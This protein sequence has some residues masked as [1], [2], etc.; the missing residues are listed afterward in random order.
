M[1]K[2]RDQPEVD[3]EKEELLRM[4]DDFLGGFEKKLDS[5][6]LKVCPAPALGQTKYS[7]C[8]ILEMKKERLNS[9][10]PT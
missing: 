10:Y 1:L 5:K 6:K 2:K 7:T 3:P 9:E 4:A 8:L